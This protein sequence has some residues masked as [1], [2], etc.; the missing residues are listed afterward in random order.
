MGFDKE[1][2]MR[3]VP[4]GCSMSS[5]RLP[6]PF[7]GQIATLHTDENESKIACTDKACGVM[8]H[9][10][11]FRDRN[12]AIAAWNRRAVSLLTYP[13]FPS[14]NQILYWAARNDIGGSLS[15]LRTIAEDLLTINFPPAESLAPDPRKGT[16]IDLVTFTLDVSDLLQWL[17]DNQH[18][19]VAAIMDERERQIQTGFT[20]EHDDQHADGSI[21]TC[22]WIIARGQAVAGCGWDSVHANNILRN[23]YGD[24]IHQL[25]IAGSLIAAEIDRLT[26]LQPESQPNNP[27]AAEVGRATPPVERDRPIAPPRNNRPR[28]YA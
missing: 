2:N 8:P 13:P 17:R 22:G 7:C 11:W 15:E 21:A 10:W 5:A 9:S 19:G 25:A 20:A 24:R 14:D 4:K 16:P 23:H 1:G 26:R 27:A 28:P 18:S 6:C 12:K 3:P